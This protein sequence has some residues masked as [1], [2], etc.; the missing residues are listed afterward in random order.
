MQYVNIIWG[1]MGFAGFLIFFV[2]TG[3]IL[4]DLVKLTRLR[5]DWF[6]FCYM[7]YNF[8]VSELPALERHPSQV[9]L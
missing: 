4:I 2:L 5:L 3:V 8:S 9:W 1:Y 6:S 7:L